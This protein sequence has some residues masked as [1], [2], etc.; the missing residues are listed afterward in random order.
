MGRV[1]YQDVRGTF[2]PEPGP[3]E[4]RCF[5]AR[6]R[7]VL[8]LLDADLAQHRH[9]LRRRAVQVRAP[10]RSLPRAAQQ[11]RYQAT[12]SGVSPEEPKRRQERGTA[13]ESMS[14]NSE[15][16]RASAY[17]R[18][19]YAQVYRKPSKRGGML[20][21]DES[22]VKGATVYRLQTLATNRLES[23]WVTPWILRSSDACS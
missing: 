18:F 17:A 5:D 8:P 22:A 4:H 10:L 13:E 20:I 3:P 1:S 14:L 15:Q 2:A 23:T 16:G 7:S 12:S 11:A 21:R 6:G 9:R 19:S